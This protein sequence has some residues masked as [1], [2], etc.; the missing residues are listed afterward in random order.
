M[1]NAVKKRISASLY[2]TRNCLGFRL[3]FWAFWQ[4]KLRSIHHFC[5]PF[6]FGTM[7]TAIDDVILF[8]PMPD[9]P[10]AAVGTGG[11]EGLNGAFKAIKDMCHPL[12][13]HLEGFVIPI[14]THLTYVH[15][16]FLTGWIHADLDIRVM[17][18]A[19]RDMRRVGESGVG[20]VG[21]MGQGALVFF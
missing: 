9:Y 7:G 16:G 4:Q 14:A 2:Y 20:R 1:R 17:A 12:P 21:R 19:C 15:R 18:F 13:G 10:T 8:D 5:D 6:L 11:S 3:E